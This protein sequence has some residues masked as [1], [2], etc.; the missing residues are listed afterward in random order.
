MQFE[1]VRT[2]AGD[3]GVLAVRGELDISTAPELGDSV[4]EAIELGIRRVVLD[5]TDTQFID[6]TACRVISQTAK[7]LGPDEGA[8]VIVC[9]S[10]NWSVYRVLDFVGLTQVFDVQP[11]PPDGLDGAES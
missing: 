11:E 5:L 9:P 3:T 10:D 1:V 7:R 4:T 2:R 8:F 6:S